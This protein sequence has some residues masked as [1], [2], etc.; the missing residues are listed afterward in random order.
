MIIR[1]CA[2]HH[3]VHS[4][5]ILILRAVNVKFLL[6]LHDIGSSFQRLCDSRTLPGL[7]LLHLLKEVRL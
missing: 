3:S 4:F 1:R 7:K 2:V 6:P 5:F